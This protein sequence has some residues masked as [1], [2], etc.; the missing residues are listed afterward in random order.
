MG[1]EVNRAAAW[2]YPDPLPAAQEIAGHVAFWRGVRIE[3]EGARRR[4]LLRLRR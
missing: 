2:C 1:D 4:G 3:E